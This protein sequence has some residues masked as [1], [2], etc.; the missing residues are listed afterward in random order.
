MFIFAT[1]FKKLFGSKKEAP[2]GGADKKQRYFNLKVSEV[3]RETK[4]AITIVF[5]D[6]ETGRFSYKPGQFLTLIVDINGEKIHRSYSLCSSPAMDE[7]LA[8][9]VKRVPNGKASNFLNDQLRAGDTIEV[10][11]PMGVFT[12]NL[13]SDRNR[14]IVLIGGGSGITPLMSI[15]RTALKEEP[16][17]RI[18]LVF[19][20]RND[21][22]IIFKERIKTLDSEN[23]NLDITHILD[24]APENWTGLS[25]LLDAAK[26]KEILEG[27]GVGEE[28]SPEYFLCGPTAMMD[29]VLESL[30]GL[31]V[32]KQRIH[33]ESFV[34]KSQN[35]VNNATKEEQ[36]AEGR[37]T[38][39]VTVLVDG[40][41][42]SFEVK[43]E[44][45]ILEA[46]LDQD[47]DMP[48]SCQSGLCTACRGKCVSGKVE[49]DESE[50]LS[51]A[52]LEEGYVLTCVGHP[53]TPDVKIEIG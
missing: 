37:D 40:E 23:T 51:E 53:T 3:I 15:L 33:K 48:F 34:S 45:T 30:E 47:I 46:G 22:S 11:E 36:K 25:G 41:E 21:N 16:N 6:H 14:H 29:V 7:K 1:M 39:T 18:S 31:G 26:V 24:E 20:N 52:E 5:D 8:V 13:Q 49:L 19:A 32:P 38:Y 35:P 17:S 42:H 10:M 12:P 44:E 2:N 4:D 27:L 28:E 50:G 9:T 43:P